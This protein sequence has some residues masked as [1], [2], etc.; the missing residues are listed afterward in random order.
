MQVHD[1]AGR[2][3]PQES[4]TNVCTC[5]FAR[6][7]LLT[8]GSAGRYRLC[9]SVGIQVHDAAGRAGPQERVKKKASKLGGSSISNLLTTRDTPGLRIE[10]SAGMQVHDAAGRA[11]PQEGMARACSITPRPDLLAAGNAVA[12]RFDKSAGIQVGVKIRRRLAGQ[13]QDHQICCER[14]PE[15]GAHRRAKAL[16]W[17]RWWIPVGFSSPHDRRH[18]ALLAAQSQA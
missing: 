1:A 4:V 10:E 8:A 15:G 11:G 18:D 5:Q 7:N 17:V 6:S 14:H 3:G 12:E 9:K 16:R 2:A 13:W